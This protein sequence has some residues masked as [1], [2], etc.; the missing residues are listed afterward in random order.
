MMKIYRPRVSSIARSITLLLFMDLLIMQIPRFHKS[1]FGIYSAGIILI[2]YLSSIF[3]FPKYVS[4]LSINQKKSRITI[5]SGHFFL[6]RRYICNISTLTYSLIKK[7][8]GRGNFYNAINI[9]SENTKVGTIEIGIGGWVGTVT[10]QIL[11]D[12]EDLNIPRLRTS[13]DV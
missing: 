12:F 8:G 5:L 1:E 7:N 13:K 9:Y 3:G 10:A 4:S 6:F 11:Q 2:I